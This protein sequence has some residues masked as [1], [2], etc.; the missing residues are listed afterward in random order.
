MEYS[1]SVASTSNSLCNANHN[2]NHERH[3]SLYTQCYLSPN[4]DSDWVQVEHLRTIILNESEKLYNQKIEDIQNQTI[5]EAAVN[6]NNKVIDE[7]QCIKELPL[8]FRPGKI[9]L[10]T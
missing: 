1:M 7:K 8:F 6:G 3:P 5:C 2:G 4:Y 9:I 10:M